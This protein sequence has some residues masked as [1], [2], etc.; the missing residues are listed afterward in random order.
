MGGDDRVSTQTKKSIDQTTT[1]VLEPTTVATPAV[2]ETSLPTP[3]PTV[4]PTLS[5][6]LSSNHEP[7]TL[8]T[9]VSTDSP[10]QLAVNANSPESS[11]SSSIDAFRLCNRELVVPQDKRKADLPEHTMDVWYQCEG[12]EYDAFGAHLKTVIQEQSTSGEHSPQW[13]RRPTALPDHKS[14][15]IHGNSHARQIA[16][17]IVC[18]YGDQVVDLYHYGDEMDPNMVL[19]VDFD[20]N[21][22]LWVVANS[23][24]P[25]TDD[26]ALQLALQLNFTDTQHLVSSIDG[27]ILGMFNKCF[28]PSSTASF[29]AHMT[30]V[31]ANRTDMSCTRKDYGPRMTSVAKVFANQPILYIPM[32]SVSR[33]TRMERVHKDIAALNE[34]RVAAMDPRR[35]ID[36]MHNEC[37]SNSRLDLSKCIN[38]ERAHTNM[39]R[40]MGPLGGHPD[41]IAWDAL[42]WLHDQWSSPSLVAS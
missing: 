28:I 2:P 39:H 18:Q 1:A 42:E 24:V 30:S 5:P 35:Y 17:A 37:G 38:N 12:E 34:N 6:T 27:I 26:W 40:C 10:S 14:L 33:S 11:S 9:V 13:G 19:R 7:T 23:Y 25:Y 15:L 41:L 20:N 8:P 4:S 3:S 32:F 22:T 29:V 31:A 21:S 16:Q 36:L